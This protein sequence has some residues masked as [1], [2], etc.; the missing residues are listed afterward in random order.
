MKTTP[1]GLD[2]WATYDIA[3]CDKS[4]LDRLAMLLM[5]WD[6]EIVAPEQWL[7]NQCATIPKKIGYRIVG[8]MPTGW[9]IRTA[10][11]ADEDKEW[12]DEVSH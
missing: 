2:L 10:L 3:M 1:I 5:E 4:D 12:N 9:R 8:T 7:F 6:Q 11:Q